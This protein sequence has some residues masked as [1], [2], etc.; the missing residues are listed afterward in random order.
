M[1]TP[2]FSISEV[3][4]DISEFECVLSSLPRSDPLFPTWL[5]VLGRARFRRYF[6]SGDKRDLDTSILQST[7]ATLLP[8]GPLIEGRVTLI[9]AF[10]SLTVALVLRSLKF[11]QLSDIK[12]CVEYLHHIRGR[13]FGPFCLDYNQA[14]ILLVRALALLLRLEPGH[15]MRD[16]E[17]MSV[18]C[19]ELIA[20]DV[21]DEELQ[22]AFE[23]LSG[24][25]VYITASWN[26]PSQTTIDCMCEANRRL[27]HLQIL[28]LALSMALF[29]RSY[30][31]KSRDDYDA[32]ITFVDRIL[33]SHS[34]GDNHDQFVGV[35]LFQ[36]AT[37]A[38]FRASLDGNP[39]YLEE[40][41]F[42]Y[43]TYLNKLSL[44]DPERP[45]IAES[46]AD[47]ENVR[48]KEF[49][50]RTRLQEANSSDPEV[51]DIT[52]HSHLVASLAKTN[53]GQYHSMSYED[54]QRYFDAIPSR[55]HVHN[56]ADVEE[57]AK[58]CRLLL[59]SPRTDPNDPITV[60]TA[61]KVGDFFF[62]AFLLGHNS[63]YLHESM[64]IYRGILNLPRAR[65]AHFWVVV[66]LI[67]SL[68]HLFM[69]SKDRKSFDEMMRLYP[70]AAI[71][72]YAQVPDRFIASCR[73]ADSARVFNHPS[74][75]TAYERA[76]SLMQE[77]LTFAPTLEIQHFRLVSMRDYYQKLPLNHASYHINTGQ[78]ENAIET[79]EQGRGLLWFEMRG[80]RTS[81]DHLRVVDS[82]L[83]EKFTA[84][85]RNLEALTTSSL[86]TWTND[87]NINIEGLDGMDPFGRLVVKQRKLLEERNS[88]VMEIQ[89]L[90]GFERF[91]MAPSFDA[92]CSSAAH[93][94]VIVINHSEWRSDIIILLR[95]SR[96]S[97]IRTSEDF[98]PRANRMRDELF[99]AREKGLESKV[100]E[101]TL[102]S[103]LANLYDLVGRQVIER[104][105]LLN[106]PE[107]S[108]VWWCPT[109]AFCSLP[110]HAMGPIRSDGAR[111][112]YF[113]DLYIP[114][115]TP[116]LSALIQ[117]RRQGAK[118][119]P[120]PP[121]LLV[122]QPDVKI[123]N[124]LQEMRIVQSVC[125]SVTT[126]TG[127]LATSTA[128]LEHL[129]DH[130]FL[131]I[132]SHGE[133]ET[134]KPFDASFKLN[135]GTRLTLLEIVRSQ[136][137]TAEFAFLSACHTAEI[138]E[139][140]IP[141]EG[142]HL[143]AA[144]QY[145]G[146]RSVVGTRWE[147]IPYQERTAEALRDAVRRLRRKRGMTLERWVNFVH[148]GA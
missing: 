83:A 141:D 75:S 105:R 31:T 123:P 5:A 84:V 72:P 11:Q 111:N 39:E 27:P 92:L 146:F 65:E 3:D 100:Y 99:G 24:A 12:R 102:R 116:T 85:N 82:S 107:Q 71:D 54:R 17:E 47:L 112:Q 58:Y 7:Y 144:V 121:V 9:A 49:G 46:L 86:S 136:L 119:Y 45:T 16:V 15:G 143:A 61:V 43:R 21:S 134:G 1:K 36:A 60:Q 132:S 127:E 142:L 51:V 63:E 101:D 53:D 91:L 126:L 62:Q 77:S 34:P 20:S 94:P 122:T 6:L 8:C 59:A 124:A 67:S 70:I 109:S 40:A 148:Y 131:H 147:G 66:R 110:L 69:L 97:L 117:S 76:I 96:P 113:S 48:F 120:I 88:I 32:A 26:E 89:A 68:S 115:Y 42:R 104:L 129:R 38:N 25:V 41:I 135:K 93:G 118:S 52:S 79:L 137:P 29:V 4:E 133:L 145:C 114:S 140:S 90:P 18:L 64:A 95:D 10:S 28:S 33:A 19:H 56:I 22:S 23:E 125:P 106:V 128:T 44:D 13:S 78:L 2:L 81:V 103:V 55:D 50:I 87:D 108:R 73:W 74:T 130:R 30:V 98:Y 14:T 57:V 37:L 80:L 139:E 138:T 35:A